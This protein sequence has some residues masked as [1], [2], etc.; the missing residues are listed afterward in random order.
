MAFT[1]DEIAN[2][3]NSSL[4][5]FL[6]KG[7]VWAQNIQDKPMLKAFQ[8][9]AGSF[10]G[11]K[12]LTVSLAVKSGQGGLSLA[13]YT[14]DDQ[15]AYSNIT[16]TQRVSYIGKEH[17]IGTKVT[18]T[19]L[20]NDGI[21]VVEDGAD[22]TT[23]EV[24]GR[25]ATALV[26]ILDEKNEIL[27]EDYNVSLDALIHGDGSADAKA[28]AG[29]G[30]F[31]LADPDTSSTGGLG[32]IANP[33][34]RNR[35]LTSAGGGIV[36]VSAT[37]GGALIT[38]MDK[39]I[40]QLARYAGGASNLKWFAGSDWIDGYKLELRSNGY[41]SQDMSRDDT[42]PD[43][44]MKDPKHAGNQIMYDPTLDDLGL[45]KRLYVIDMS[46]RGIKILYFGKRMARHNPARPYDRY[47]MYNGITTTAVM[48]ARSL[49]SSGVYDIA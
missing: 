43:G 36:T 2:I 16:G 3:A 9:S 30:A 27:L 37:A 26:N 40:R 24:N 12:G 47:V 31:I 41:Y 35:A 38:A 18:M 13:G 7:K 19:E 14:G 20:K 21:D 44:S 28:L 22:Q 48:I 49:R 17:H 6:D 15:V 5:V 11:G 1:A 25:E 45:A 32:R 29:I 8:A 34:W 10:S 33:Y 46:K 23:E 39:E 4:E 42:Q